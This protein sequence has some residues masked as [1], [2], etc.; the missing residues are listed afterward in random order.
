MKL[1]LDDDE[2][3]V[4]D[5][6]FSVILVTISTPAITDSL[7]IL[8]DELNIID[9]ICSLLCVILSGSECALIV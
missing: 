6:F 4:V 8:L 3:V 9:F 5:A 1:F 2:G 7:F